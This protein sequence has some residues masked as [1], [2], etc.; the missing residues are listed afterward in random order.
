MPPIMGTTAFLVADML[1]IPY[2]RLAAAAFIPALL[3]Y[4]GIFMTVDIYSVKNGIG[5]SN[6]A[7]PNAKEMLKK[8]YLFIPLVFLICILSFTNIT[9]T[10]AGLYTNIVTIAMVMLNRETRLTKEKIKGIFLST[11]KSTVPVA[12]ACAAVGIITGVI[13]GSGLGNRISAGLV[14]FAGDNMLLLLFLTMIVSLILGM[15]LPT[16]AAY[17]VLAVLVAPALTDMGVSPL[18][19]HLFILYFGII[20]S[21]TPPVAL[22]AYAAAGLAGAN[23]TQTGFKAFCLS[24]SGFILPFIWVFSEELLGIGA[25]YEVLMAAVSALIG[26][27]CLSC[28]VEKFFW[29]WRITIWE[30]GFLIAAALGLLIPGIVTD[31]MGLVVLMLLF[32]YHRLRDQKTTANV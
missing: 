20:S 19:A 31:M 18:A 29:K 17:L 6:E 3:F 32:F 28:S 15:G 16:T 26:V 12:V 27:F 21:V 30:Q 13:M 8:V 4:A 22:S 23:P 25:W 9:I 14:N 24:I 2:V 5:K 11:A 1:G 7:L 10:R